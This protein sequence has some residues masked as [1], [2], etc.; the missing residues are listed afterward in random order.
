MNRLGPARK[1]GMGEQTGEDEED[2]KRKDGASDIPS[3]S[4]SKPS[5]GDADTTT[6]AVISTAV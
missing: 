5:V 2:K 6:G 4:G 1:D 3:A